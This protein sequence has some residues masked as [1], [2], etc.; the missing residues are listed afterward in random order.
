MP[1][2]NANANANA[3]IGNL[4]QKIFLFETPKETFTGK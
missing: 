4:P 2:A 3:D 1:S